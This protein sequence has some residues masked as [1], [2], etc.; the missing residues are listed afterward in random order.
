MPFLSFSDNLLQ[1]AYTIRQNDV[2]D[3]EIKYALFRFEVQFP[4]KVS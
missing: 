2:D 3:V 4:L 1:G